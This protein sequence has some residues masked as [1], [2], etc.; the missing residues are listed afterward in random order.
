MMLMHKRKVSGVVLIY[1]LE[2]TLLE[3]HDAL[4]S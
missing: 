3:S 4:Y 2:N 1:V